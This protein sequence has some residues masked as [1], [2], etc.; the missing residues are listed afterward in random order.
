[1]PWPSSPPVVLLLLYISISIA[2]AS[3]AHS[4]IAIVELAAGNTVNIDDLVHDFA[5]LA[6]RADTSSRVQ[7]RA[8]LR[9]ALFAGFSIAIT[10]KTAAAAVASLHHVRRHPAVIRAWSV[11]RVSTTSASK[12]LPAST[13]ASSDEDEDAY[14][15]ELFPPH[16]Q[17]GL[18]RLHA[19]GV[20]GQGI[21]IAVLDTG[22]D[23]KQRAFGYKI[24]TD[25]KL[26]YGYDW[27]TQQ[28]DPYVDCS[29]HGTH[30]LGL[31]AADKTRFGVV[32]AAPRATVELHRVFDCD[33]KADE[34]VLFAALTA[35]WMRGVH[36]INCS[37]GLS[38]AYESAISTLAARIMANGTY[39]Q[40]TA[41]NKGPRPFT[42]NA[43]GASH[44][45]PAVGSVDCTSSA[46]YFW[47]GSFYAD[48]VAH[49]LQWVPGLT[50]HTVTRFPDNLAVWAPLE[51]RPE[52]A[53]W[54]PDAFPESL[55]VPDMEMHVLL[56]RLDF[57][58]I[59]MKEINAIIKPKYVLTYHPATNDSAYPG[60]YFPSWPL[61]T[62]PHTKAL[63]TLEH[64]TA[65]AILQRVLTGSDVHITLATS[66][67]FQDRA[68][69]TLN[70]RTGGRMTEFSAWGPSVH[71]EAGV[72]FAAPG[73]R[74]LSTVPRLYG[75]FGQLTGTSM[76]APIVSGV[77]ALL[78]QMHPDWT[79]NT[80]RNV[81]ATT[82]R[83]MSYTDNSTLDYGFLAPVIQQGGGLIDAYAAAH[84]KALV[85]VSALDFGDLTHK[86]VSLSFTV[87][88]IGQQTLRYTLNHIGAASGYAKV[89]GNATAFADDKYLEQSQMLM[90]VFANVHITP[91]TLELQA[92]QTAAV[93]VSVTPPTN[94]D[95]TRVPFY[96]GYIALNSTDDQQNLTLPYS[97]IAA[98]LD[99]DFKLLPIGSVRA[100][101]YDEH[102]QTTSV[103]GAD[104]TFRIESTQNGTLSTSGAWPSITFGAPLVQIQD[105]Q[106]SLL[107]IGTGQIVATHSLTHSDWANKYWPWDGTYNAAPSSG[108]YVWTL[109]YSSL[110]S[111]AENRDYLEMQTDSF[112]IIVHDQPN[113]EDSI[114]DYD[115]VV[116]E[117]GPADGW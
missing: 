112:D 25:L 104:S 70:Y 10:S 72:T 75:G 69:Y 60:M 78:R 1:M 102:L 99:T 110:S 45:V 50:N 77:V 44:D 100:A 74:I 46:S 21:R 103:I 85:N 98:R 47:N 15:D 109:R 5:R 80:V 26:T 65:V 108:S 111:S 73:G 81:L 79:P 43:P 33:D 68:M 31:L 76:A 35:A 22:F 94:M 48:G 52:N 55:Q 24:G 96:G 29:H 89:S 88:N 37:W 63:A 56:V 116:C 97:G 113:P 6:Q 19:Q 51:K 87:T 82:A 93:R 12:L 23:Y 92:G 41:G 13:S 7:Q 58:G 53:A 86:P 34:D 38:N 95:P 83:P 90:A 106:V 91:A 11:S 62:L 4:Q 66:E 54:Q 67:S 16:V 84:V 32:G 2:S 42:I 107:N 49:E 36:V 30:V 17:I 39:V 114:P 9:S 18:D 64:D 40:F 105:A 59:Y 115:M 101:I 14:A 3:A 57:F 27:T 8:D 61:S 117:I 28:P 20:T 71:G